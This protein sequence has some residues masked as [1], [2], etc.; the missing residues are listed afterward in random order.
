ML[1]EPKKVLVIGDIIL[2]QYVSGEVSRISPEAPIPILDK[3]KTYYK[4]GGAANV[5]MNLKMLGASVWIIGR[6][7]SDSEG[8]IV[9]RLLSE[10]DI[11]VD[12]LVKDEYL[13]TT[14]KTRFMSGTHQLLRVDRESKESLDNN[15]DFVE[16]LD[17]DLER[18]F[19]YF[20]AIIVS[21]YNKGVV[22][23]KLLQKLRDLQYQYAKIL[24]GDTKK[25][26]LNL[27]R[28]FT[29]LTPNKSE[30][31]KMIGKQIDTKWLNEE[32]VKHTEIIKE[33]YSINQMLVTLSEDG[34][35]AR[36]YSE[37]LR[38]PA[39]PKEVVDI[40]GCGD[41]V[42]AVLT[43]ALACDYIFFSAVR[44]ANQAA[45][46]VVSKT[47]TAYVTQEDLC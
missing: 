18:H 6:I 7:G 32:L 9:K 28:H 45:G 31:E 30:F 14:I 35:F 10:N 39:V 43:L 22:C 44:L 40:T 29:C 25:T 41:T 1:F 3:Q 2:D 27:F 13:P 23:F 15:P 46:I 36:N 33:K 47:G 21:D 11:N 17:T 26:D 38:I 16:S 34:M 5:A 20:D 12:L 24:V 19:K 4:L 37:C 42:T 8:E